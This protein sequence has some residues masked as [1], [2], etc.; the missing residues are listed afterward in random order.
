[1]SN[2]YFTDFET[3]SSPHNASLKKF[4]GDFILSSV[5]DARCRNFPQ[6]G[7]RASSP[8]VRGSAVPP[9]RSLKI[10]L[11]EKISFG[12]TLI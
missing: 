8:A 7:L 3:I 4:S 2:Q 10:A 12:S 6:N 1:M 9:E 5:P 11:A